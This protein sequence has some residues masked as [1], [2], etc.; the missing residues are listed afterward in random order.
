MPGT[1]P[2]TGNAAPPPGDII[3]NDW[4]GSYEEWLDI[5][6][7][8][9]AENYAR[10]NK[11]W[12]Q[13]S[14]G[15]IG[16]PRA[17]DFGT[18]ANG[19]TAHISDQTYLFFKNYLKEHA[20]S[21]PYIINQY[22]TPPAKH[23]TFEP[24]PNG[25]GAIQ[26]AHD[27]S[28]TAIADAQNKSAE[29]VAAG[30]D[31]ASIQSAQIG[32]DAQIKS[33]GM[34][35]EA[36]KQI[37]SMEDATRRYIAEGDWGTQRYVAELND[38]GATARL[39]MELGMRDKELVQRTVAETNR[40]GEEMTKLALAVA[41]YDSELAASP[42]NWLKYAAWLQNRGMV[43]NGLNLAM[44][45]DLVPDNQISPADV[46][47]TTGSGIAAMQTA[48]QTQQAQISGQSGGSVGY[49]NDQQLN[50]MPV[51]AYGND[52]QQNAVPKQ[53]QIAP[54]TKPPTAAELNT[55]AGSGNYA[56]IA[57]NLLGANGLGQDNA[58]TSGDLNAIGAGLQTSGK[59][60]ASFGAWN[61]PTTNALGMTV[62]E[63]TGNKVDYR[64]FSNLLPSQ[65]EMKFG[66]IESIGRPTA[67]YTK[68]MELSRPKGAAN[69][70][71][72]A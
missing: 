56:D 5:A 6:A 61:G 68:E 53:T 46:A 58:P 69:A 12:E 14:F 44:A 26:A 7:R 9:M 24:N 59:R 19:G 54:A 39:Q 22:G 33:T 72:Y 3:S 60:I 63:P 70:V 35:I 51:I 49:G 43:V 1:V 71:S 37:A 28:A 42:R 2:Y 65:Q 50:Q 57:R 52:G 11:E 30:H 15:G 36:D 48:Q 23:A 32:A 21:D 4:Q 47:N 17:Q 20:G 8:T 40:H 31:A 29:K 41:Q 27:A 62:G 38:K 55:Q 67:D 16:Q 64:Q 45:A 34:R 13:L 25:A 66:A 18:G 10:G